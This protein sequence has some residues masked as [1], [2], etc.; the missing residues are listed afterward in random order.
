MSDS[1]AKLRGRKARRL[2]AAF[3]TTR[4]CDGCDLCC[5]APPIREMDKPPGVPC[6]KLCGEPGRSCSVYDRRP[7]LCRQF[8]CLWRMSDHWLPDWARPADCGYLL[9]FN[10]LDV[11]PGVVTVHPDPAR[12]EAWKSIYGQTL[13]V[14]LAEQW[15]CIVAVGTAPW[16]THVICPD[17]SMLVVAENPWIVKEDGTVG[18][19]SET[20][21]PDR[22]PLKERA[23]ESVFDWKLATP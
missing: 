19:P 17:G 6:A 1:L 13:L 10:R 7:E 22:R 15:N 3:P 23:R 8:H 5:T 20:F 16:T 4:T 18:A 14:N 2:T 11:F 9:S 21:G 12:P